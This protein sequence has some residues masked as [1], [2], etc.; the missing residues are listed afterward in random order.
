MS[1]NPFPLPRRAIL[2]GILLAGTTAGILVCWSALRTNGAF[3]FPLDDPWI[4][5][6]FARNLR[7]Y[8]SFSYFKNE[9]ATSG[10]TSPLYTFLLAVGFLFTPN[11]MVLS[12]VLGILF[13]V[14]GAFLLHRIADTLFERAPLLPLAATALFLLE[15]RL[16]WAALSGM[17]TTLFIFLLLATWYFFRRRSARWLGVSAGLLLWTRPEALL[18]FGILGIDAAYE[19]LR[20]RK[21]PQRKK[22][23]PVETP[24]YRWLYSAALIA[25]AL[26][27]TY[28]AFNYVLSGTVLPNTYGAK[29]RY[30]GAGGTGFPAAVFHFLTDNHFSVLATA[31][32]IGSAAI[33]WSIVRRRRQELIVPLLWPIALFL[34]YWQRLPFLYQEGRYL[35]PLLPFFIILGMHGIEMAIR[36]GGRFISFLSRSSGS[37]LFAG[38]IVIVIFAQFVVAAWHMRDTYAAECKYI[39]ERQ[40]RT[41]VWIREFTPPDAVIGTHDVGAIGF[42]SHRRVVDMVGLV[43]PGMIDHIGSF[44]GLRTFLAAN[45]VSHIAVLRNWFDVANQPALFSTD[46]RNPEIMQVFAFDPGHIHFVPQN[47]SRMTDEAEFRLSR[48]EVQYAGPL[49]QQSLRIDPQCARSHYLLGMAFLA[50]GKKEDG[51]RE[52]TSALAL[53]PDY[54]EA[55][56]A[57]LRLEEP[58]T[59]DKMQ[60]AGAQH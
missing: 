51:A 16:I 29:T 48:G 37:R 56:L 12:Y 45:H 27:A 15:P 3:G 26:G 41:A 9:M 14:C 57:L 25:L 2:A 1:M 47:A 35:M 52:F 34:A 53:Q 11:E 17:E 60:A 20:T 31:A 46:Q 4:H 7:E 44:D 19:T 39:T 55:R 18:F 23:A 42:Y 6:Q 22:H 28:A 50:I 8:A 33:L 43:S 10:S 21:S 49:L 36:A 5:L 30:Y 58:T 32:A 38:A 40:V 24:D 13:L 54:K 59:S